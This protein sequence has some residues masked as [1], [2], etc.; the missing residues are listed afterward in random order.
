MIECLDAILQDDV[1]ALVFSSMSG[2][3]GRGVFE[4]V[5]QALKLSKPVYYIY[6]NDL[7]K[8][9]NLEFEIINENR[10]VYAVVKQI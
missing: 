9:Y 6:N 10:R 8:C 1:T 3:V 5:N 2:V 7:Q 4:E